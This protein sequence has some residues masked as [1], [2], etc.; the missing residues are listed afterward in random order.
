MALSRVHRS[1]GRS[2]GGG[3]TISRRAGGSSAGGIPPSQPTGNTFLSTHRGGAAGAS[4]ILGGAGNSRLRATSRSQGAP[5]NA[6]RIR[7]VNPG[8]TA[9]RSI[10]VSGS[11]ITVNLAVTAGV[12]DA[13]ETAGSIRTALNANAPAFALATFDLPAGSDGTGVVTA[14]AFTNLAG[15]RVGQSQGDIVPGPHPG[16]SYGR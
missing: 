3:G 4:L 10:S 12:I 14:Q 5:A 13:T 11:D 2:S 1:T 8:G 6:I 7:L 16:E 9:A 15:G